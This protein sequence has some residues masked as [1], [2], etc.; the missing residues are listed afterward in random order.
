MDIFFGLVLFIGLPILI[1]WLIVKNR[2]DTRELLKKR[3]SI[4][5]EKRNIDRK[6]F[7]WNIK[8]I[9][10]S[11]IDNLSIESDINFDLKID[12]KTNTAKVLVENKHIGNIDLNEFN[13]ARFYFNN[14]DYVLK[15]TIS[16]KKVNNRKTLII[17]LKVVKSYLS[18]ELSEVNENTEDLEESTSYAKE[19][20]KAEF[21]EM[22]STKF[23]S[24][25]LYPIKDLPDNGSF[26]YKKKVVIT[27]GFESFP[28]REALAKR[29]W[30]LGAD[31]DTAIGKKTDIA[32]VGSYNVGPSKH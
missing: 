2:K 5:N 24:K 18:E 3:E 1:I 32:L 9:H 16:D 4:I 19:F 13:K 27:G 29:L 22:K 25:Y 12:D 23:P 26:F 17:T 8:P 21:M 11:L 14:T 20:G 28:F 30:E 7:V 15:S 10:Q 6:T 31:V